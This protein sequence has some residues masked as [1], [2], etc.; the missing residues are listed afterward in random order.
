MTKSELI[1]T[2]AAKLPHLPARDVEFVVNTLFG[3]MT[4]AMK[5]GDRIEIRGFGS[6]SVRHRQ[7]RLGRNPKTGDVIEVPFKRVPFFTV[8]HELKER[9]NG[10]STVD[11][12][13]EES[14]EEATPTLGASG[15]AV[16]PATLG[17]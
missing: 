16:E 8:G 3:A 6:F 1:Q 7:S 4:D 5:Q 12:P 9:V 14:P 15:A 13:H 17:E 10:G 2:I 11:G